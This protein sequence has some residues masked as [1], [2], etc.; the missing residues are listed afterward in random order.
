MEIVGKNRKCLEAF[1]N[2]TMGSFCGIISI[3]VER[4]STSSLMAMPGIKLIFRI[5]ILSTPVHTV[6][7]ALFS[8]CYTHVWETCTV[9]EFCDHM[10][11]YGCL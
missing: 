6:L 3:V 9:P 11:L 7:Y 10:H 4:P 5:S 2:S 8:D 1:L